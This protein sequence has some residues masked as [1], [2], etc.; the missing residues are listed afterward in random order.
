MDE[1]KQLRRG[2]A[3]CRAVLRLTT[4]PMAV[5]AIDELIGQTLTRLEQIKRGANSTVADDP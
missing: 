2:L 3:R 5:A 1:E 4:D